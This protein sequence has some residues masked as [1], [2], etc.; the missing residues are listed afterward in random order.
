MDWQEGKIG[1]PA[2]DLAVVT[3]GA[4]K[5]LGVG[6][7]LERLVEFYNELVEQECTDFCS[8]RLRA[9]ISFRLVS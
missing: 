6:H 1:D 7:G 4:R 3:R 8:C 5:P 9:A 2:Y